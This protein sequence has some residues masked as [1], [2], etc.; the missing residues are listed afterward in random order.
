[1]NK[2]ELLNETENLICN[3][4]N[5]DY[6]EMIRDLLGET[7]MDDL[8][9][10]LTEKTEEELKTFITKY[11]M[12]TYT[13]KSNYE[14]E[15]K[16]DSPEEALTIWHETIEEN[17][18]SS[19]ITIMNEFSESLIAE[20]T[21]DLCCAENPL[22]QKAGCILDG[23]G[24]IMGNEGMFDCKDGDTTWYDLEDMIV[25]ILNK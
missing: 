7:I 17:L 11:S 21:I 20:K 23:I 1:M 19:N 18:A 12:K 8:L 9:G 14:K 6:V 4:T 3:S 24:A 15:I 5:D 16:A 13:I 22:R 25:D 2:E 10:I